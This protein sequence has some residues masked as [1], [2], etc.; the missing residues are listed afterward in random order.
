MDEYRVCTVGMEG[1]L[2]YYEV[3]TCVDDIEAI[4][5]ANLMRRKYNIEL[6]CGDRLVTQLQH[7]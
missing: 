5:K 4:S 2:V 3:L 6:W 1:R 7:I